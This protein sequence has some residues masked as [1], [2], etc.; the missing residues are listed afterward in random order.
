[1]NTYIYAPK[2][3][4]ITSIEASEGETVEEG[5]TLLNMA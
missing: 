1:M 3:G 5:Q 2:S 4:Q